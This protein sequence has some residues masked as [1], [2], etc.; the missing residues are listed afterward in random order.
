MFLNPNSELRQAYRIG[1]T[2]L[3][4]NESIPIER[5]DIPFPPGTWVRDTRSNTQYITLEGGGERVIT[6]DELLRGATYSQIVS[7]EPGKAGLPPWYSGV[8]TWVLRVNVLLALLFVVLIVLRY[9][10]AR[11]TAG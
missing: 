4:I 11:R 3:K 2:D 5:F 10:R 1:I 7:S 9:R 6:A 8:R